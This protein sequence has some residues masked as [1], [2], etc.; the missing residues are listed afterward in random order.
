MQSEQLTIARF[1]SEY[2]YARVERGW[3]FAGLRTATTL[4]A[5]L[6]YRHATRLRGVEAV[7]RQTETTFSSS[8]SSV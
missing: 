2:T 1:G 8:G 6:D 5:R 3:I 4:A 7:S